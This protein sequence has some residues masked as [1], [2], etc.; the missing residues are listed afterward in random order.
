MGWLEFNHPDR[1]PLIWHTPN[2]TKATASYM[3]KRQKMGVKAGVGDIIDFGRIRGAFELKRLDKSKCKVS[4]DQRDFLQATDDSGGFA[5][6]VYGYEQFKLAY[7]DYL[8]FVRLS[9]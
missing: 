3:Q 2:E 6:I 7:A 5:A 4:K 1:W 8:E 9:G